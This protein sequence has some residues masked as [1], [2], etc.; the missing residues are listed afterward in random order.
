MS[1]HHRVKCV[2]CGQVMLFCQYPFER[3]SDEQ[4]QGHFQKILKRIINVD[5]HLPSDVPVSRECKD[6][7]SQILVGNASHRLSIPDIQ[8]HPLVSTA[9][10]KHW[11]AITVVLTSLCSTFGFKF[12]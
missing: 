9:F 12:M 6:L 11:H 10:P 2:I 1:E 7:L 8:R 4:D 3:A 5:Y